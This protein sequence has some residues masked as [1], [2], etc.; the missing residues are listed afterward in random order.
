MVD[1]RA[2]LDN[3]KKTIVTAR[4]G[5]AEESIHQPGL[6]GHCTKILRCQRIS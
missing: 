1:Q 2:L 3:K 5:N 6:Y 4:K